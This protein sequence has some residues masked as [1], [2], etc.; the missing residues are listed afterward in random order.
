MADVRRDMERFLRQQLF[1]QRAAPLTCFALRSA[2]VG[3]RG[4][5]V[6]TFEI[7][8]GFNGDHI[9]MLVDDILMR[10]QADADGMGTKL[11]RYTLIALEVGKKDGSR[12]PF[13]VRGEGDEDDGD[14]EEQPNEKGLTSQLMRHNEALMRMNT[15]AMGGI[16]NALTKRLEAAERF[17]E[18]LI[19]QRHEYL[20]SLENAKSLEHDRDMEA[21]QISGHETRKAELFKKLEM[22]LPL[23]VNKITGHKLLPEAVGGDVFSTLA[24]SLTPDQLQGIAVYLTPEQQMMFLTLLKS[25]KDA[26][27]KQNGVS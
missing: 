2:G 3:S 11:Q 21:L 27:Q 1:R 24:N 13:R 7:P 26:S 16:L 8:E 10:A 18:T 19:S 23:V 15:M 6:D 14:G 12:F 20:Q 4:Q 9:G 22:I 25:A 17:N 5:A